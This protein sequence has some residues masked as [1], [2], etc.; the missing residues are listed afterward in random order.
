MGL[1]VSSAS[2]A[3][4]R[5]SQHSNCR[6]FHHHWPGL[7][8]TSKSSSSSSN[9]SP[10][11]LPMTKMPWPSGWG[12]CCQG[13]RCPR[14]RSPSVCWWSAST[15]LPALIDDIT[16]P[17]PKSKNLITLYH[18]IIFNFSTI[19]WPLWLHNKKNWNEPILLLCYAAPKSCASSD[20]SGTSALPLTPVTPE[21]EMDPE[22]MIQRFVRD[23]LFN[24]PEQGCPISQPWSTWLHLA[25][26]H[27]L[28]KSCSGQDQGRPSCG[29][30]SL[31]SASRRRRTSSPR[32]S[33]VEPSHSW[34]CQPWTIWDTE[35]T[36]EALVPSR[37][38]DQSA[39]GFE[40]S[41]ALTFWSVTQSRCLDCSQQEA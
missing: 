12:S 28:P 16:W 36:L 2:Q 41:M 27:F 13:R 40:G 6:I 3:Y 39:C 25:Q 9:P 38:R 23:T 4:W 10:Q 17:S 22:P 14:S 35:L 18:F 33:A 32:A 7:P 20:D 37:K 15:H 5:I 24:L 29:C 31:P 11:P 34:T 1:A 8:T 19:S 30:T 26:V 21:A